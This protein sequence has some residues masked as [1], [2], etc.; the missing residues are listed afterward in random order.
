MSGKVNQIRNNLAKIIQINEEKQ[1]MLEDEFFQEKDGNQESI[2]N[3]ISKSVENFFKQSIMKQL[4]LESTQKAAETSQ[5]QYVG[6][7]IADQETS[8][9]TFWKRFRIQQ[10]EFEKKIFLHEK[11]DDFK[12]YF[13]IKKKNQEGNLE[14]KILATPEDYLALKYQKALK[15]KKKSK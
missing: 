4:K 14:R 12:K 11:I 2:S 15:S 6:V 7:V 1:V 3:A 5:K 10:K 9:K 8:G 13:Q